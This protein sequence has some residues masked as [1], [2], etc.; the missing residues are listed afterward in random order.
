LRL[1]EM[2]R[3]IHQNNKMSDKLVEQTK[4]QK[5]IDIFDIF[6]SDSDGIIS[7][8]KIDLHTLPPELLEVFSPL[9]CEMEEIGTSLDRDEFIDA[10]L[11]MFSVSM[12]ILLYIYFQTLNVSQRNQI[13]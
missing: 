6:D 1:A 7:A 2:R 12:H 13:L 11:R 10:A 3:S 5:L 9:L 8:H 4:R